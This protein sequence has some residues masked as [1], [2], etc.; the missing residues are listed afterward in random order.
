MANASARPQRIRV[1][2]TCW[3]AYRFVVRR[4][5]QYWRL[6]T[7]TA[8]AATAAAFLLGI[9]DPNPEDGWWWAAALSFAQSA[10]TAL[11]SVPL[12]IVLHRY[13]LVAGEGNLDLPR[14]PLKGRTLRYSITSIVLVAIGESIFAM[15]PNLDDDVA[16]AV[17]FLIVPIITMVFIEALFGFVFVENAIDVQLRIKRLAGLVWPNLLRLCGLVC[18]VG[19]IPLLVVAAIVIPLIA[20]DSN[21]D[22][23]HFEYAFSM[24][25][26]VA[27]LVIGA[28][29]VIAVSRAYREVNGGPLLPATAGP[30]A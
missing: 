8:I 13:V 12:S 23:P 7:L 25:G 27:Q 18:V 14:T 17:A 10:A 24:G 5:P 9:P 21:F 30:S 2:A 1:F 11:I 6:A 4:F 3:F 29:W 15:P 26:V 28:L 16:K 22:E 20:L 19:A